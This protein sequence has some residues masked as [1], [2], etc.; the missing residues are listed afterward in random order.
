MGRSKETG[1]N[2]FPTL[3]CVLPA[4]SDETSEA[5]QLQVFALSGVVSKSKLIIK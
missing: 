4:S 5:G 2:L 1:A 3:C